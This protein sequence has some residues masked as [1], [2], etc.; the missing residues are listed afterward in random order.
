MPHSL[1]HP[2]R[3]SLFA[4]FLLLSLGLNAA[5][6]RSSDGATSDRFGNSVS[7]S[8]SSGIVGARFDDIGANSNQGSAYLFRNLNTAT[9]T[10]TETARLT[11][12]DGAAGDQ[13]GISVS[14]SGNS[15]IV[16]AF[17]DNIGANSSQGSAYLF[18]NLDTATG[19]VTEAAK[20]ISSDGVAVDQ[21]GG[22]VSLSGN[23]AVVAAR[24]HDAGPIINQGAAYLYR[25]LDTASGIVTQNAK[26][27]PSQGGAIVQF[28]ASV[29]HFGNSAIVGATS[30][31]LASGLKDRQGSV[32]LFRGLD[33]ATGTITENAKLIASDGGALDFMG[34]ALSLSGNSAIAGIRNHDIGA[35]S[36]Q[37]AAYLFRNLDTATGTVTQSAKLTASDGTAGDQFGVSVGLSGNS[38]IVGAFGDTV[39]SNT[40]QGSAYLFRN[41]DTATGTITQSAK[42]M[43]SNG[44]TSDGFGVSVS[45]NGDSIL[46]GAHEEAGTLPNNGKAYTG[47]VSSFTTLDQGAAHKIISGISFESRENWI[48]GRTTDSNRITLAAGN[49]ANVT[50]ASKQ[51][52]IGM[53]AGSDGNILEVQGVLVASIVNIGTLTGS[54]G[55]QLR[56]GNTAAIDAVSFTMG[57]SSSLAIEGDYTMIGALLTYLDDTSLQVW[58]GTALETLTAGNQ[59]D[60]LGISFTGGYTT[61][62]GVPE[63]SA[64]LLSI[65]SLLLLL[66]RR[67]FRP[68][69]SDPSLPGAPRSSRPRCG[70]RKSNF[71]AVGVA[72]F[73]LPWILTVSGILPA[74]ETGSGGLTEAQDPPPP[75]DSWETENGITGAGAT[76]DSD[77]DGIPNGIEFVIGG[78]PSGPG[79]DSSSLLPVITLDADYLYFIFRRTDAAAGYNPYV[80]YSSSLGLWAMA[81]PGVDGVFIEEAIDFYGPGVARVTVQIPR[82]LASGPK[83]F[84]RLGVE[85][86]P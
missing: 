24:F 41:L 82:N 54:V 37:G 35:N 34:D 4:G 23:S 39:G 47:S 11:P 81:D 14:I 55:N 61:F 20:L 29:S 77:G 76:A 53:N 8:G 33:I 12:S 59:S 43:A 5:E 30:D 71:L 31:G 32:L 63:P 6:L 80:E 28:G 86:M 49:T 19:T 73:A 17:I 18:R 10:V 70:G 36:G 44:G 50:A 52:Y 56:L 40:S 57:K 51:V 65:S 68:V 75:Y 72:A 48:I 79:S 66:A 16:G 74:A 60:L 22:S 9:G 84:A 38:G 69:A 25:N 3:L 83:M 13:L 1:L 27:L 78:D 45:M 7:L 21:F 67:R 64:A 26:L 46:I 85:I 58:N 62:T 2:I 15:G 42:L